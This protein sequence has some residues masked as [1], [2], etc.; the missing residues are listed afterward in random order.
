V[1]LLVLDG[2]DYRAHGLIRRPD[3]LLVHSDQRAEHFSCNRRWNA[4]LARDIDGRGPF[5]GVG[6]SLG[7]LA[8][9]Y[10][11]WTHPGHLKGLLLQSGSFFHSHTERYERHFV[12][13]ERVH[14]FV[15]RVLHDRGHP[16]RIPI[17][18]TCGLEEENRDNNR[19]L[20]DALAAH[21]W[22]VRLVEHP[23]GHD[24]DA[25]QLA[26]REELPRLERRVARARAG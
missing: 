22:D 11:H 20:A 25:W 7:A 5:V 13:F 23:G 12:R 4:Q 17:T 2:P 9:L 10:L 15:D 19:P 26:L 16:P 6:T 8:L 21:G 18:M 1:R 3:A 24:W 14:R